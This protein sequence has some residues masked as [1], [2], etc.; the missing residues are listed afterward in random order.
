MRRISTHILDIVL[1]KPAGNVP[2]QLEKQDA[3]GDWR[4]VNSAATDLNGR[5]PQLLQEG[6]DLS[7]AVY[8]LI[9]DTGSYYRPQRIEALYPGVEITFQA[10]EGETHFHIPLL[11]SPNGYTTYRGS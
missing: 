1:G 4:L 2:V 11:L 9:F 7:A 3:A 6:E 8:R 5:C 10:R